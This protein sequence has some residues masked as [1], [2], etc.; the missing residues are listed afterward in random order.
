MISEAANNGKPGKSPGSTG[1]R[2]CRPSERRL[3][4]QMIF[5]AILDEG[6]KLTEEFLG[7]IEL[8]AEGAANRKIVCESLAES[9][10]ATS[11]GQGRA[12]D[13]RASRSTLA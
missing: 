8:K 9:I 4:C 10:H 11:P 13:R 2:K 5:A 12:I 7:S 3:G 6:E 1:L